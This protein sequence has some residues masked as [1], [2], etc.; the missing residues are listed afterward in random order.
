MVA[1]RMAAAE[2]V[3]CEPQPE[4]GREPS[5]L[6]A[7]HPPVGGEGD[8]WRRGGMEGRG[9]GRRAFRWREGECAHMEVL[10]AV[11][12]PEPVP[13]REERRGEWPCTCRPCQP[14]PQHHPVC[15]CGGGAPFDGVSVSARTWGG[16]VLCVCL[17]QYLGETGGKGRCFVLAGLGRSLFLAGL[18]G[19]GERERGREEEREGVRKRGGRE[20]G[21]MDLGGGLVLAGLVLAVLAL[22]G[23]GGGW[24]GGA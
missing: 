10:C 17:S 13:G 18:G 4:G 5:F 23:R 11:F 8:E 19:E 22:L 2:G 6:A 21:V 12:V 24:G 1:M 20:E 9:G 3:G 15:V 14:W 7:H 16:C